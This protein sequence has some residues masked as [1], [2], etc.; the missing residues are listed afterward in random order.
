[1]TT[2]LWPTN[3]C[4]YVAPRAW[5]LT[6]WRA[7]ISCILFSIIF[8]PEFVR[9]GVSDLS[10][11]YAKVAGGFRFIDLA[12]LLLVFCH[13]V[14]L[15]CLRGKVVRFPQP[16][17]MPGLAFL[18]CIAVAIA[19]GHSHGG[20]NFFFD[21]RGL[22]LGIGLY[23][24][25]SLWLRN[26]SDV[27]AVLRVFAVY[28]AARIGLLFALYLAGYRETLAGVPIP[29][30][31]GP[32]LSCIVFT[33]L[34]AFRYRESCRGAS[35]LLWSGVAL[36]AY[37]FVLLCFRRTYWGELAVGTFILLLLQKRHRIRNV[38]LLAG[39]VAVAAVILGASFSSRMR[40]L[41][42]TRDDSDF[43][44]DNANHVYD[45]IDAWYQVQQSPVMGIGVGTSYSTWH[46]RNWKTE[47]V[48]VHNAPLHVWL[49]YGIAGLI[50]YVWF[51]LAL[52]RWLY[53]RSTTVTSPHPT[54]LA[55]A[56]AY[57]TAQF[58]MT[59][60]FAPWPYSELQLTTLI[61]FILA[62]AAAATSD[63]PLSL[64]CDS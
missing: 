41:D 33:A 10:L 42:V 54:F 50:C 59:L 7:L 25:W 13:V 34:L 29:I 32:V 15:G 40:S 5:T 17:M 49:K 9:D 51:H 23:F 64:R 39:M 2:A 62:A 3:S 45:L 38:V 43:S 56:F 55:A 14:V 30:F 61:S 20:S 31:D 21:W 12:I 35:K 22:A 48:M 18:G 53:R 16:L 47:S 46:I 58:A 27:A 24:V 8:L 44:A 57:L 26:A 52:L 37:L 4:P 1:M 60:G 19:Y 36:A 11:P 63:S 6:F 28:M